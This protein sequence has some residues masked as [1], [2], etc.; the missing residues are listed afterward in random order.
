MDLPAGLVV[1]RSPGRRAGWSP[2][3]AGCSARS[4]A[5]RRRRRPTASTVVSR[6]VPTT[7]TRADGTGARSW[8][9]TRPESRGWVRDAC[10]IRTFSVTGYCSTWSEG[11]TVMVT[12]SEKAGRGG[13]PSALQKW[14]VALTLLRLGHDRR[15]RVGLGRV[16]ELALQE[17]VVDHGEPAQPG[18]RQAEE[19]VLLLD[20]QRGRLRR[21]GGR[22]VGAV[23]AQRRRPAG[24]DVAVALHHAGGRRA[25]PG[26]R[27]GRAGT[28]SPWRASGL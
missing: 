11:C 25:G 16:L 18:Q 9:R 20:L 1:D 24:I 26:S 13:T 4:R 12:V 7:L 6:P 28:G 23:H 21:P 3:P 22:Q 15:E 2:S 27:P 10:S 8:S 19:A 17:A 5:R 14:P